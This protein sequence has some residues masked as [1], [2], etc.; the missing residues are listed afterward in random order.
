[1]AYVRFRRP[2]SAWVHI[3]YVNNIPPEHY[4][5]IS[6]A[7]F[8]G[9]RLSPMYLYVFIVHSTQAF[10]H[11][12]KRF[13]CILKSYEIL[14]ACLVYPEVATFITILP[15]WVHCGVSGVVMAKVSA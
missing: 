5:R 13:G 4:G 14:S 7:P 11:A 10:L 12:I 3:V 6:Q 15:V 9:E 1:M 2:L 8:F